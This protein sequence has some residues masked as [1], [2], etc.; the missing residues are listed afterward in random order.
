MAER[1]QLQ[2]T[3]GDFNVFFFGKRAEIFT[4]S[5]SLLNGE[6][7]LNWRNKFLRDYEEN[8][9]G[10][11][12][13]EKKA[14]AYMLYDDVIREGYILSA[15]LGQNS[16]VDGVVKFNF[17]MLVTNRRI[18]NEPPP[19]RKGVI[20]LA[21]KGQEGQGITEFRFIRSFDPSVGGDLPGVV[22]ASNDLK[23]LPSGEV[24][25]EPDA[26]AKPFPFVQDLALP[27]PQPP[28]DTKQQLISLSLKALD[29]IRGAGKIS[30][31][32][33][34]IDHDVIFDFIRDVKL[35]TTTK[36]IISGKRSL[37]VENFKGDELVLL[38][39]EGRLK[40][41]ALSLKQAVDVADSLATTSSARVG[42][43]DLVDDLKSLAAFFRTDATDS[44]TNTPPGATPQNVSKAVRISGSPGQPQIPVGPEVD[45]RS[46]L[47]LR[48]VEGQPAANS[49][50]G[51]S[52]SAPRITLRSRR[53]STRQRP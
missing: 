21:D 30:A 46:V 37:D 41:D 10:T 29:Q 34:T 12:A 43:D 3:F 7:N 19:S 40:L 33:A 14:R 47:N 31:S 52:F 11:K 45:F 16:M 4:Y 24:T 17:T 42:N 22:T 44:A 6:G 53:F 50:S 26:D 39:L 27:G 36:L 20:T 23:T 18:L 2:E 51:T 38:L 35:G 15:G 1:F 32:G 13:A 9:R 8:L 5:G 25:A 48:K 49:R 28:D